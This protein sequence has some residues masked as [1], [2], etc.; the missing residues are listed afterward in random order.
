MEKIT[1]QGR[2]IQVD[3]TDDALTSSAGS[4]F[5]AETARRLGLPSMIESSIR[6]KRRKR[7][8]SDSAMLLSLVYSLACGEGAL[9]D[10]D[11][12][13]ADVA[14]RE[15]SRLSSVPDSRRLGECLHR[16]DDSSV[17]ALHGVARKLGRA[18]VGEVVKHELKTKGYVPLFIDGTGIEVS[19]SY[20]E[21]VGKGYDERPQ[22]WLHNAFIGGLWV[23]HRLNPG[24]CGV[25]AG[26]REQ[27]ENDVAPLLEGV[28]NV[29]ARLD[30]AYYS[31][32]CVEPVAALGWDYSASVTHGVYKKPLREEASDLPAEAW[33][34]ISS[35]E[36]AAVIR[37][38]PRG[39]SREQS[40]VVVRTWW[41][42]AQRLAMPRDSFIL[43]SR[44]NL[45]LSDI[46][47]RH[48]GKCGQENAMKGPLID[49]DLHHPP[50]LRLDANR[51]F[52]AAGQMAQMLLVA[53]QYKLLP[54]AARAHGIRMVIRDLVR[55][56]GKLVR[57]GRGLV[58]KFSKSS[59]RLDWLVYAADR[60]AENT[61]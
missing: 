55:V 18:L 34:K 44:T 6:L 53:A 36:E 5:I 27:V 4:L 20:C 16:F 60:L 52:Y 24:G 7:G 33:E 39:W 42:G 58:M 56:A 43:V 48:R 26:T 30:N 22:L 17:A 46:V 49:L 32:E 10:V 23:S 61:A 19:G 57:T 8:S 45:P 25:S 40:Y 31:R 2:K 9:R 50:C 12:L 59:F 3:F 13:A 35:T 38:H 15:A 47:A 28:S 54:E 14:R 51:A 41:D 29:W 11:R 1:R 37:H 21:G